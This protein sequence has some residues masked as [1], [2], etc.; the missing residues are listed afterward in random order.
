M[1]TLDRPSTTQ[2]LRQV[3]NA[4][5]RSA[6]DMLGKLFVRQLLKR[7]RLGIGP[8]AAVAVLK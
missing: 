4:L 7:G 8:Q 5:L 2:G 1:Q 6:G 3:E